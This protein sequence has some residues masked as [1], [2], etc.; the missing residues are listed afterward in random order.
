MGGRIGFDD[1]RKVVKEHSSAQPDAA[2][3]FAEGIETCS[4]AETHWAFVPAS[5]NSPQASAVGVVSCPY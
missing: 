1:E 4:H 5:G 2:A 3:A